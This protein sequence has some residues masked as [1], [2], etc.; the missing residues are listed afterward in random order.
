MNLKPLNLTTLSNDIKLQ[1]LEVPST[2]TLD[3]EGVKSMM[4]ISAAFDGVNQGM[5]FPID[6]AVGNLTDIQKKHLY[7]ILSNKEALVFHNAIHD[8]R[9]L[10]R[11]GFDWQGWFWDTM[12]MCHWIDEE[13]LN[14]KLDNCSKHYGGQPKEM[15]AAMSA[16]LDSDEWAT[17]PVGL[18]DQYSSN[19]AFITHELF[20]KIL[21]LF[22][23]EGF[24]SLWEVEQKF[25]RTAM[26]PMI[27]RGIKID[28][29]FCIREYMR[30][31]GI[32]AE[33]R[34]SLGF[35]PSSPKAL[36][37]FLIEELGLPVAKHTPA[38]LKC[39]EGKSPVYA[40]QGKP[41]FD[42]EAMAEYDELLEKNGDPRA[43]TI[44]R[45]R[46][47]QK[48]TSSNYKP[49]IELAD[50]NAV[51]HPGYKLHGTK[52]GRLSCE[53]PNLQQIPKTS[54]KDWN[55]SL[56][57]A[58]IA[59]EGFKLWSFDYR[60]LQFRM[61]CAYAKQW[62]LID[63]FNDLSRDAFTEMAKQ[64]DWL[65]DNVK[66]L[67]YLILFGGGG[68]KASTSFGVTI[69]EGREIVEEFHAH[70]PKIR[71]IA[72]KAEQAARRHG[73]VSLWTGRRRHF[74]RRGSRTPPPFYRSFNAV[75]QGGESEIV[76][77]ALI[78]LVEQV[79]NDE[80]YP[81]LQIHDEIV[82]EIAEGKE[83][84]YIPLVQKVMEEAPKEF[85][86]FVGV[87]VQFPTSCSPW[88]EK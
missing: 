63:I 49:Y 54:K 73:S 76:K 86:E 40:H 44:L 14:Y 20:N 62:D 18:M 21:P 9:V 55:G 8:L 59:R 78:A 24:V 65:R 4:G 69:S 81:V 13:M 1:M 16:L 3:T 32:M 61:T 45:Y 25:L 43:K 71:P 22:E 74:K 7:S 60:Q 51:L 46:G 67:V 83:D 50:N 29:E 85:C 56:K 35:N 26:G 68:R 23:A 53:Q 11:H 52:T 36:E 42:K 70:Y 48:T 79:C 33:D 82:L 2:V 57:K 34:K 15:P 30:G 84:Y 28:T 47:W 31:V 87:D 5:Y 88:G 80:C 39:K 41:S 58:F 19:D 10:A 75:I 72:K 77:R 6:H 38:C 17:V 27:D 37:A 64:M 66:T 12:L